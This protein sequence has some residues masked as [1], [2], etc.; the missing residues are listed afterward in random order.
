MILSIRQA[1]NIYTQE[2]YCLAKLDIQILI[3]FILDKPKEY[4]I[5]YPNFELT[6]EQSTKLKQYCVKRSTGFPIAYIIGY[7]EFYSLEY[8]VN[9]NVLIPR[10]ETEILVDYVL[11]KS[12]I[13]DKILDLGTGSGIIAIT[14]AKHKSLQV[15][16]V[17]IS[18]QALEVAKLNAK[19]HNIEI[20]FIQSDWFNNININEK[21]NIIVSNPPYIS[22]LDEHLKQDIKFEPIKALT[23]GKNGLYHIQNII[24]HAKNFLENNGY[25]MLEHGY[26]QA[27]NVKILLDKNNY[28]NIFHIQDLAGHTRATIA[29]YIL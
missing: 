6:I 15:T 12:N 28:Q 29:Q 17:D 21:F 24:F 18:Q 2:P 5:M 4:L 1:I 11:E 3:G 22:I 10:P 13:N 7:K 14:I 23:D 27:N 25:L 9:E 19:K 20:R 26:N 8:I 16:A